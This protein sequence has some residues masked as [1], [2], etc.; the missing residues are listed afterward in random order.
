MSWWVGIGMSAVV[1]TVCPMT[2]AYPV[3]VLPAIAAAT[4]PAVSSRSTP[5][6]FEQSSGSPASTGPD[7]TA[8][9]LG[10]EAALFDPYGELDAP[11]VE[12]ALQRTARTLGAD[13]HVRAERTV[14]AGLDERM[15]QLES[16]CPTWTTGTERAGDLVVVMYS[17]VE[18]EASVY[19]GA[20]QGLA[21]QDRWEQAVDAMTVR[22][23][24]GD[25]TGGVIDGLG[26]L[27]DPTT[28]SVSG[29]ARDAGG[30]VGEESSD[31]PG[32]PGS[33]WL[34]IVGV[35]ALLSYRIVRYFRTGEWSDEASDGDSTAE[36]TRSSRRR[37]FGGF[38]S[39]ARRSSRSSSRRSSSG[40]KR[41]S[42]GGTK[43]W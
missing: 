32:V 22:F 28:S 9:L 30:T 24:V 34:I 19:Y 33:V 10:C 27:S 8:D 17:S 7:G 14:D 5:N 39:G 23:R 3:T 18:R 12:R 43:K 29:D 4:V 13:V 37:S 20:D 40:S 11:E 15:T 26:A 6:T 25:F 36:R 41:R 2:A 31:S 38:G 35:A 16:R 21:L 42:G 1:Y